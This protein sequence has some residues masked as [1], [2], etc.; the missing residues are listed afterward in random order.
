MSCIA[1]FADLPLKFVGCRNFSKSVGTFPIFYNA[2]NNKLNSF[3]HKVGQ[4]DWS[5]C[6][7]TVPSCA[8][9]ELEIPSRDLMSYM[10]KNY[11]SPI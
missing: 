1:F 6:V 10:G 9:E 5:R 11:S 2:V 7:S 3:K 4:T 8:P